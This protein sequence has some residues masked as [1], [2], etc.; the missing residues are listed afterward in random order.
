MHSSFKNLRLHILGF[1]FL[2]TNVTQATAQELQSTR[3]VIYSKPVEL[4]WSTMSWPSINYMRTAIDG[5]AAIY[6]L[7][8]D[9]TLK[10]KINIVLPGGVYTF[11]KEDRPAFGAM[12]DLLLLGGSGK[13]SFDEIENYVSEHGINLT[14][15]ILAN[16]QIILS[17]DALSQDFPKVLEL[18]RG[19]LL[20]PR[21]EA[22]S[23]TLWQQKVNDNFKNLLDFNTFE[24]QYR[25]IDQQANSILFGKDHYLATTFT[26]SAPKTIKQV[27][28]E[29]VKDIYKKSLSRNGLNVFLSGSY[30]QNDFEKLKKLVGDLPSL[31]PRIRIWLP[32]KEIA[33][34]KNSSAIRTVIIRKPDMTQ[35]SISL[36]YYFPKTGELNSI[37]L[38]QYDILEEIFSSTGGIVGND[39]FSKAL[40]SESGISYSAR[41]QFNDA[42]LYPNTNFGVFN[43][44]FQSPN[45]RLPEAIKLATNTWN[46]FIQKGISQDEL[47]DKRTAMINR[48]LA[49]ELTVFNKSDGIMSQILKGNLPSVN[50]IEYNLA[51]LDKQKNVKD[52]NKVLKNLNKET[53]YPVLVIMGNPSSEQINQLKKIKGIEILDNVELSTFIKPYLE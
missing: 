28:L 21:F 33:D 12:G 16:G 24:K 20:Q 14:T 17:A 6:T 36:R 26:R 37:E 19:V 8:S 41:A 44:M 53:I 30:S 9:A 50:P 2:W 38:A 35:C 4:D 39:R 23:F 29:K 22:N 46:D 49:S 45:E 27:T 1:I 11:P 48:M 47:D 7:E 15:N 10:F 51:S 25:L 3:P 5:G 52:L 40:R 13:Y 43:L 18:L 42:A 34:E 31:N 32:E